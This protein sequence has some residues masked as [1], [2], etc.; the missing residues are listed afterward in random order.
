[1]RKYV[2][3]APFA[4]LCAIVSTAGASDFPPAPV[5]PPAAVEVAPPAAVEI[6]TPETYVYPYR[7][8]YY[9]RYYAPYAYYP[10]GRHYAYGSYPRHRHW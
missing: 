2:L 5:A 4:V 8:G 7:Y 3:L 10:Y 1:M 9:P 6:V